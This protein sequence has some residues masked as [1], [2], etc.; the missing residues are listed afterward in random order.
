MFWKIVGSIVGLCLLLAAALFAVRVASRDNPPSPTELRK[1]VAD[2]V[3]VERWIARC[4]ALSDTRGAPAGLELQ[5][6]PPGGPPLDPRAVHP[7]YFRVAAMNNALAERRV[8]FDVH[9]S[10]AFVRAE[11]ATWASVLLG[12]ATTVM[13][14]LAATDLVDKATGK[15]T[16]IRVGALVLPA[17]GTAA[18][19]AIAFYEPGALL[20]SRK[21][22]A[23]AAEQLHL[24]MGQGVWKLSC[25][26]KP[27]A[28]LDTG[29]AAL[30]E[31]W[32][33]RFQELVPRNDAKAS[34]GSG[35]AAAGGG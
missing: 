4:L 11:V 2:R 8:A 10:D 3:L 17:I 34:G 12:L 33:Q 16:W 15:G 28:P 25:F 20:A 30:F 24:Q 21:A 5:A 22:Q 27:E 7:V 29:Q 14:A 19:A 26:D 13:V 1:I 31:G 6:A 23:A 35:G 32:S 18:A 9:W